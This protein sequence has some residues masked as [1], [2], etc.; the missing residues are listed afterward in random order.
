TTR[1]PSAVTL[2]CNSHSVVLLTDDGSCRNAPVLRSTLA[3]SMLSVPGPSLCASATT[4]ALAAGALPAITA[5]AAA[6]TLRVVSLMSIP[7][8]PTKTLSQRTRLGEVP[9]RSAGHSPASV[10]RPPG[11]RGCSGGRARRPGGPDLHP[12]RRRE[13]LG[14]TASNLAMRAGTK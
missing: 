5:V 10:R 12:R 1:L 4:S 3:R 13:H 8:L 6:S 9:D 7:P 2:G 11:R 14:A